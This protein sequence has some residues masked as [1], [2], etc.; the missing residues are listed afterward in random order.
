ML[1]QRERQRAVKRFQVMTKCSDENEMAYYLEQADYNPD[2]AIARYNEDL[3]WEREN[4][5]PPPQSKPITKKS[6]KR[7][8][9]VYQRCSTRREFLSFI[10]IL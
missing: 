10:I 3:E 6:S 4:P 1:L 9:P 8:P 5:L 7:N 2:I